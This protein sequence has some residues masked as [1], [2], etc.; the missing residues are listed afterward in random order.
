MHSMCGPWGVIRGSHQKHDCDAG[1]EGSA[2]VH[3]TPNGQRCVEFPRLFTNVLDI[4]S[5]L[6]QYAHHTCT[7]TYTGLFKMSFFL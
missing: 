7:N 5:G 2:V 4:D 3:K 6:A 1:F